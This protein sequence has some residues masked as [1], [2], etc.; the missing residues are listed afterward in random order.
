MLRKI[1]KLCLVLSWMV[2]I[3]SFSRDSGVDSTKKS[4]GVIV[5][6]SETLLNKKIS[7]EEKKFLTEKYDFFIRK[8]AHFTLYFILGFLVLWFIKEF[9][10]FSWKNVFITILF[11]FLYACSD[12]IHQLFVTERSGE[13]LDVF[14]DTLGGASATLCYSLWR[15]RYHE[16]TTATH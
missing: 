5:W 2:I 16:K 3:F 8:T 15:R 14:L 12:E 9:H 6:I 4:D 13:I 7:T 11:V 1:L 10:P